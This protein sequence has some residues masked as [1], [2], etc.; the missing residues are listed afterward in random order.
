MQLPINKDGNIEL[1]LFEIISEVINK[2]TEEERQTIVEYFGFQKPIRKWM[3]ERLADEYSRPSF[4]ESVHD[5][6]FALLKAI[7]QEELEYYADLIAQ[8]VAGERRHNKAYWEQ[9]W[10]CQKNNITAMD[11]FPHQALKSSDWNWKNEVAE[12][13]KEIIKQERPD[14]LEVKVEGKA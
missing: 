7:K 14:L 2:A 6:R 12:T 10:W 3:V 13:V 1:D 9:Y 11:G 5:D 4:Y 8:K